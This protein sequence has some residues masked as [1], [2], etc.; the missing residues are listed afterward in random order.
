MTNLDNTRN[1]IKAK[2]Y[3]EQVTAVLQTLSIT[4]EITIARLKKET[5][6]NVK[7]LSTLIHD[8]MNVGLVETLVDPRVSR[9]D[10]TAETLYINITEGGRA[11]LLSDL[12]K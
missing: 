9:E 6:L 12:S 8:V 10:I 11:Y 7:Y 5:H 2:L 1:A 3:R 4:G